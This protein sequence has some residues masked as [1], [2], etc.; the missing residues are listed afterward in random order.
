MQDGVFTYLIDKEN[1]IAEVSENWLA[2]ARNNAWASECRPDNV[3][4]QPLWRFIQGKATRHLY[5][6]IFR[7]IRG[8]KRVGPIPFRCDSPE[9]KR[10]MSLLPLSSPDGGI[11]IVSHVV[12]T[13]PCDSV[14]LFDQNTPRSTHFIRICSVCK[15]IATPDAEWVEVE[16]GLIRLRLFEADE[17]PEL[18]HGLCPACY[19]HVLAELESSDKNNEN[20]R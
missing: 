11:R 20:D 19:Q 3:I 5:E 14:K 15:K 10:Y 8:G 1:V 12:R 6:Q 7:Q 18:T 9:E 13:E 17:L 2:F 4:G 16:E